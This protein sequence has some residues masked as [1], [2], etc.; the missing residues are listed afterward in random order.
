MSHYVFIS[1]VKNKLLLCPVSIRNKIDVERKNE[2]T[3][4]LEGKEVI[5][6]TKLNQIITEEIKQL[7]WKIDPTIRKVKPTKEDSK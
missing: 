7:T 5:D 6:Y 4:T 2:Y 3:K 1:A